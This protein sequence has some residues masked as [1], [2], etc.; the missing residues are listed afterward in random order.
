MELKW[1]SVSHRIEFAAVKAT[2][3]LA[4][5]LPL[6]WGLAYGAFLG[7][8]V[9]DV[10][11]VRRS[12]TL[13]NLRSALGRETAEAERV[14][15][16]RR[17]YMNFGRFM[18]E[19]ARFPLLKSE[20]IRSLLTF[21]GLEHLDRSLERGKGALIIPGHFGDWELLGVS[22]Q[23]IGYKMNFLVGE[24][25]NRAVDD[26]MNDLRAGT[27][28]AIIPKG[29]SVRGVIQALRRNE[30]VAFLADQDA[31]RHG[32]FV[33]FFGRP[34][35]T[36]KGPAA[37]ALK[38]GALIIPAFIIRKGGGKHEVVLEEPIE[39]VPSEDPE[40][41]VRRYTQAHVAVLERYVRSYPDH[42]F[43]AHKRWKTRPPG[44]RKSERA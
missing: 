15:I 4:R 11:R 13:E 32:V 28:V 27:G 3:G 17:A 21:R 16:G 34:A 9:F 26:L 35:S 29:Y 25:H 44:E 20:N 7:R 42:W 38:T 6:A 40:E 18:I 39:A 31:R 41:D 30:L 5:V 12:V 10:F 2:A 33:D 19:Y 37:F 24:Q 8:L 23:L 1:K 43:W 36:P 22:F 14:R